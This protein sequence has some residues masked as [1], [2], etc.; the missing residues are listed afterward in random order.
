MTSCRGGETVTVSG[1]AYDGNMRTM[2]HSSDDAPS[3]QTQHLDLL[4]SRVVQVSAVSV[5]RFGSIPVRL[6]KGGKDKEKY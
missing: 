1:L 3:A 5:V 6:T 4:F 2:A